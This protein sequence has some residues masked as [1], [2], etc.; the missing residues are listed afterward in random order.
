MKTTQ[1]N[2]DELA[3]YMQRY[4]Y[5]EFDEVSEDPVFMVFSTNKNG[6][7]SLGKPGTTDLNK[8]VLLKCLLLSRFNNLTVEVSSIK[9]WVLLKISEKQPTYKLQL[10]LF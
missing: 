3:L 5:F 9:E 6:N 2:V 1:F 8:A 7:K 4:S 10:T